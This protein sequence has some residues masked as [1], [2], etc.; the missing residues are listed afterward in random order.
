M[1]RT[2]RIRWERV[3]AGH[4]RSKCGN[5]EVWLTATPGGGDTWNARSYGEAKYNLGYLATAKRWCE[6][7]E[8]GRGE[9]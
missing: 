5:H 1:S 7:R 4:L 8:R 6:E 9:K 2:K 3:S